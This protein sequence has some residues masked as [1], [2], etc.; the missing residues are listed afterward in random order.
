MTKPTP[1]YTPT[2]F[3]MPSARPL[4][5]PRTALAA[6]AAVLLLALP[7]ADC[8]ARGLTEGR[9]A[10]RIARRQPG[11][12]ARPEVTVEGLPFLL[13]AA[14]DSYPEVRVRADGTT[15][16]GRPVTADL[17]LEG[18]SPRGG[19]YR[20]SA[21]SARFTAPYASLG[22]GTDTATRLSDAGGGRLLVRRSVLG[23][24]LDLTAEVRLEGSVLSL[25]AESASL[26]GRPL[27]PDSPLI[28][29]ALARQTR[30]LPELPLGLRPTGVSAGPDGVTVTARAGNV[31][32]G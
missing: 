9:L 31:A 19:G 29:Q 27:D 3:R 20:A 11:L 16:A 5:R 4:R 15:G 28:A 13:Q 7:V 12:T 18:V 14:R 10:D 6:A 1:T 22:D 25:R 30:T 17:T 32:L 24:P 21:A 26:G 2:R 23:V 8:A